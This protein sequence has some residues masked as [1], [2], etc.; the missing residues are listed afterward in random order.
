MRSLAIDFGS[1]TIKGAVLDLDSGEVQH[2]VRQPFPDAIAGLPAGYHEVNPNE[3]LRASRAVLEQLVNIAPDARQL[4]CAGQMGGCVLIDNQQRPLSNYLSWRDQRSLQIGHG[5]KN[6]LQTLRDV[7]TDQQFQQLG[8][9]LKPGSVTSLLYWL[10]EH[11]QLPQGAQV[12]SLGDFVI[13][14]FCKCRPLWDRTMAIG[15]I[16]MAN[17]S[18]HH[19]AFEAAGLSDV[20]W[21]SI[22]QDAQPVGK[23]PAELGGLECYC[24]VGDQQAALLG[25]DL[26]PVE[27]SINCSTG[28]Q[29][30][31]ISQKF[32]PGNYQTRYWFG[33]GYLN[34]ITHIPA[35]R[36]LTVLHDLLVELAK[37]AGVPIENSWQLIAQAAQRAHDANTSNPTFGGCGLSCDLSF[38]DSAL[39]FQGRIEGIT[40]DNLSVGNLFEA[41]FDYMTNA[42]DTCARRLDYLNHC[43]RLVVSGGLMQ[44]FPTLRARLEQRFLLPIRE[45]EATE[46]TLL[47]LLTIARGHNC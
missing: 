20:I 2:I 8:C 27:L 15:L 24:V 13:A 46:E 25:V 31:L 1:S 44:N 16:N 41:A 9:E 22:S 45:V 10:K 4:F 35:G 21:P 18:W 36:S 38:F 42:Y 39:G 23:L 40:T 3:I 28:S 7:W 26:Q 12:V 37:L 47:G 5:G 14:S 33:G 30:S 11:Q 6:Y 32:C 34:T 19:G 29:V 43:K 17:G